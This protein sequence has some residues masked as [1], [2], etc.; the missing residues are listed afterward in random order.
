MR[1][2]RASRQGRN[3]DTTRGARAERSEQ[4]QFVRENVPIKYLNERV[5]RRRE[6][7][8]RRNRRARGGAEKRKREKGEKKK[9]KTSLFFSLQKRVGSL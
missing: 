5:T 1:I 3:K 6:G 7:E 9:R 8:R 4:A 2:A